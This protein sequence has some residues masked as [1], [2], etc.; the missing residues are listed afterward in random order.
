FRHTLLLRCNNEA[1]L[2]TSAFFEVK[3]KI[4]TVVNKLRMLLPLHESY[5]YIKDDKHIPLDDYDTSNLQVL[6]EIDSFRRLYN[7]PP[8]MVISYDRHALHGIYNADFR[9]TF[10]L[11]L[12]F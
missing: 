7:L 5:S 9:M 4:N 6:K 12:R 10:D 2:N 11:N 3:Q 8:E 1:D